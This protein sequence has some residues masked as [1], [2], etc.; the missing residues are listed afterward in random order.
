MA[1]LLKTPE[2]KQIMAACMNSTK[3]TAKVLFPERF[4]NPF[5]S[6]HDQIFKLIDDDS[7]QRVAIAAPRGFGKT[8]INTI[9]HPAKRILFQEK[10]FIVPVSAT[11]TNAV[12]QGENLKRELMTN[13]NIGK[14]FGP[15]KSDVFSKDCWIT[16]SGTM[17]MPRGAGQQV[18]GILYGNQRPDLIVVDDLE[19]AESVMNP[20]QR[21]KLKDWFFADLCNCVDRSSKD[22]RIIVIGT[23]LHE[24]A[25]LVNLLEDP[26][27]HS[28]RL[29]ICDDNLK[30]NWPDF[31]PDAEVRKLYEGFKRRNQLDVFYREYRNIPISTE[32]ATFKS[33]MFKY[34][35]ETELTESHLT[36]VVIVDPAKTVQLHSADS[37]VV[38]WGVDRT[39]KQLHFRDCV[40]EAMY[41]DQLYD[42]MFDMVVRLNAQ[43]LAVEVTS[44]NEFIIQPIKNE[45]R[46]RGIFPMFLALNARGKKEE[47]V[48]WLAPFYRQGYITHNKAVS[49]KYE[50]QLLTFPRS[51][52]W[53]VMDAAA[54]IVEVMEKE[55]IYFDPMDSP[56]DTDEFAQLENEP[57][58]ALDSYQII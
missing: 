46:K 8:T 14:L 27:W 37:A 33:E 7:K 56:D 29:E 36:N 12:M 35:D 16:R 2:M 18:R 57:E 22:W 54:Y 25:L 1:D 55:A 48:A 40:A 39:S 45:M 49:E 3:V 23:V 44:L 32:N 5:S 17:V 28:V 15:V 6:L 47:R 41:P 9:T 50:Q 38:G 10:K 11:A 20:E 31:M 21:Q 52:K 42:A 4:Y 58:R 43:I 53:D 13:V 51:K 34:H 19:D 26:E 30:S 24:D